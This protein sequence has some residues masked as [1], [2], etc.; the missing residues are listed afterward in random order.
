MRLLE[1][2]EEQHETVSGAITLL[3]DESGELNIEAATGMT[4][5]VQRRAKYKLGEGITGRVVESGRPV[6]VPRV[7]QEP[8][9][10]DR[11]AV[12]RDG[13]HEELSF[14]CV[15]VLVQGKTS[16][17]LGVTFPYDRER[18]FGRQAEFLGVVAS[19]I[20]QAVRVHT[21]VET[22]RERLLTERET[23]RRS[24]LSPHGRV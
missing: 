3:D 19:M 1:I 24:R 11:T 23:R 9:F 20:G 2:L 7:S 12:W 13:A 8:L 4:W 16:G 14:V 21:L 6:I 18:N 5:R 17:S 22:E 10:L 15:P